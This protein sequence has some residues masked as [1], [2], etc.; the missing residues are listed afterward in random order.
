M[1]SILHFEKK[2]SNTPVTQILAPFIEQAGIQ[3]LIKREDLIHPEIAGNKWRKLKYNLI[4]AREKRINTLLTFGGAYSN[5][6]YATAAAGK[7]FGFQTM[8]IIRGE[9]PEILNPTLD[10]AKRSKMQLH[11]VSR[12]SYRDK[13]QFLNQLPFDLKSVYILPEGGTND[14][15]LKGCAEIVKNFDN[16]SKIDY[17]CTPSGTGGTLA[18]IITSLATQQTAIGFSALKGDFLKSDVEKLLSNIDF[19]PHSTWSINTDYHFGGYAKFDEKLIRFINEFKQNHRIQ[20][21][22]IYTGKMFYGISI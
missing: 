3:L 16:H 20:L 14:L 1:N 19:L 15:A 9:R 2:F 7:Y 13:N 11:F 12:A 5:H 8:G 22:P 4:K 17:W 21:D 10:F 6:I 18:G